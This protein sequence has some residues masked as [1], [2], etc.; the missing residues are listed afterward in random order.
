MQMQQISCP[1]PD[2]NAGTNAVREAIRG[3]LE[4]VV[5]G[6]RW[7]PLRSDGSF[8]RGASFQTVGVFP[9]QFHCVLKCAP[10]STPCESTEATA[11]HT[12]VQDLATLNGV[13]LELL[14]FAE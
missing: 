3:V 2:A 12:T 9:A 8:C 6:G 5:G 7:S 11:M 4:A 1:V 14:C 13:E 10:I